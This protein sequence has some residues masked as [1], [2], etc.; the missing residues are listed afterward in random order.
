MIHVVLFLAGAVVGGAVGWLVALGLARNA[1][2]RVAPPLPEEVLAS[3]T[4]SHL[5]SSLSAE[6]TFEPLAYVLVERCAVRTGLPTALVMRERGGAPAFIMAV[7]GQLDGRLLGLEVPLDSPGGRAITQGI[8]IVG[9][10]DEKVVNVSRGDRRQYQGGGVAVPISQG[11][12]AL[13]AIIAFGE[14][15]AGAQDAVDGLSQEVRKFAPVLVPA[16]LTAVSARRAETDELTQLPNRRALSAAIARST[17]G[18]RVSLIVL[19]VDHFKAV[20]DSLGHQAGD[21]ALRHIA[22]LVKEAVRPRDTAARIGGEEFAVWLPGADLKTGQEVAERLRAS[23]EAAPF[24]FGG[25][26]RQITVSCGVAAHPQ[27]IRSIDNLMT[28]ADAALYAAKG[29]GRN[30]VVVSMERAG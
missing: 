8:P 12:Q 11:G 23:V 13:G 5:A 27:P 22:R 15:P 6:S 25:N 16:F 26:E 29:A 2:P 14:P 1:E 18:D 28:A 17:S 19:D 24:R 7:A 3:D 9:A 21:A 4:A 20:N 30:R 10:R